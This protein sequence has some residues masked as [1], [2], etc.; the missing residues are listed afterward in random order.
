MLDPTAACI[1]VIFGASGD[2][3]RRKLVPALFDLHVAGL[4]PARLAVLG[5]SRTP[6][7][8]DG[9]RD[10]CK[11]FCATRRAFDEDTWHAFANRLHYHAGDAGQASAWQH[12][13]P[14]L[15]SLCERYGVGG[16]T[17]FYLSVGPDLFE[18]IIENLGASGLVRGGKAWC[19]SPAEA[20]RRPRII[21][22]KPFGSDLASAEH[23]NRV[24]GRVFE[25]DDVFRI[26]HY[27]GKETVQ[28]LLVFRFANLLFE[29]L[30]NRQFVD[31]VQITAAERVGVE[32]RA[33]YYD[34]SGAL[35]DMIQSHLLQ[36]MAVVAMEPPNSFRAADLRSGQRHV[37]EAVHP[38]AREEVPL[39]A[40][41][42][43]YGRGTTDDESLAAYGEESGVP[44]GSSCE[45][46]AALRLSIDNWRWDGVP[47]FLRTGKRMRRKL[48]QFVINFKPAPHLFRHSDH[49]HIRPRRNR[50]VVNVQPDEGISLRFE[51]KVPGHGLHLASALLDFDYQRQF[52][53]EPSE[54]YATLLLDAIAGEQSHFKDRNEVEAAWRIVMPVLDYWRDHPREGLASY[55]SGSWGPTDAD[56]LIKPW[57]RWHNPEGPLSRTG[58]PRQVEQPE[59]RR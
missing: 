14:A 42:G 55:A 53:A 15:R 47:F 5:V 11:P 1:L 50:L 39:V 19:Q 40:V 26:D 17:L 4:L 13:A 43:Q 37:L 48:T 28:N 29:P 9:F 31:S 34:R 10:R 56:D 22:E 27:L 51:G 2:L 58:D 36:L 41:R 32:G 49:S 57:G 21:V 3:T 25:D 8:D 35:R 20:T 23:L 33:G 44:A 46:F 7:G 18:P 12:I 52:Q 30:W 59:A 38:I 54:A 45:T 6:L 16:N 24:L